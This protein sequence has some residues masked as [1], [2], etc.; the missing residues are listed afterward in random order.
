MQPVSQQATGI[1][2]VLQQSPLLRD[3]CAMLVATAGAVALVK[4]FEKLVREG[5]IGQVEQL[6]A[7][8]TLAGVVLIHVHMYMHAAALR[9]F[10]VDMHALHACKGH[11]E[12]SRE[13]LCSW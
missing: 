13:A 9:R 12:S 2:T 10:A 7:L 1:L 5:I 3:T 11:W 4:V 8:D 6:S